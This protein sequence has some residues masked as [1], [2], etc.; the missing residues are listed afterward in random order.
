MTTLDRMPPATRDTIAALIER[1][2]S[3]GP[4]GAATDGRAGSAIVED[5]S[6][7]TGSLRP[8]AASLPPDRK[9][10]VAVELLTTPAEAITAAIRSSVQN[11]LSRRPR[12]GPS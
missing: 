4:V 10:A 6:I 2:P 3:A 11:R 8:R 5:P 1:C 7:R 12:S 9:R